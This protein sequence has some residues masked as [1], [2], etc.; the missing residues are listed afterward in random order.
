MR[1]L[2]LA[3]LA[4]PAMAEDWKPLVEKQAAPILKDRKYAAVVVGVLDKDQEE[5]FAFGE[6]NGMAPDCCSVFEIGSITKVFTGILLADRVKAGV[7]KLDDPVQKHLPDGWVMP[8]RDDR[9]ITLLHLATHTS[10][11][12][13]VPYGFLSVMIAH[14][15]DPFARF[16][17]DALI[18]G[19]P[20]TEIRNPIGARHEYSNLGVGLLGDAL[21][22]ASKAKNYE[23]ILN[24]RV[25]S[26]LGLDDTGIT[27]TDAQKKRIVSGFDGKGKAQ[28]NWDFATCGACGA[29]RSTVADMLKFVKINMEPEGPLKDALLMAQQ[30]WRDI[31]GED[32]QIGLC[33]FRYPSG[34][35]LFRIWHNG[36]TGGYH[37]F[38]GFI[39]GRGGVVVLCNV[40]TF[41][42]DDLGFAVLKK[43][44]TGK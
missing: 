32:E 9:D 4:C 17:R 31:K 20:K 12:S 37:S 34:K 23:A 10:G 36:Q 29:I 5:I 35:K 15:E 22:H 8:R 38:L 13:R 1:L 39:P 26:P 27:L 7:V 19:L 42:V 16:D 21:A 41:Q 30:N 3:T 33:W 24:E 25:L 28:P 14:P 11:I 6:S 44:V 2:L 40:T 18:K 43:M